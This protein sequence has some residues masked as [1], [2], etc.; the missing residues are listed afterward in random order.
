M[1]GPLERHREAGIQGY[2]NTGIQICRDAE[3]QAVR[4]RDRDRQREKERRRRPRN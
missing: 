1:D 4:G 3:R 2:K